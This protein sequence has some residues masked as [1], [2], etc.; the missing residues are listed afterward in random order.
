MG[1]GRVLAKGLLVQF[2]E[3]LGVVPDSA[4]GICLH[5]EAVQGAIDLAQFDERLG[6]VVVDVL[7]ETG[8][9]GQRRQAVRIGEV[10]EQADLCR[11]GDVRRAATFDTRRQN[12]RDVPATCEVHGG[13]GLVLPRLHHR[14]EL[15]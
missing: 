5:V 15:R 8:A 7:L 14:L 10:L 3:R 12:R 4:L 6:V 11:E 13:A 1:E 9:V 2:L